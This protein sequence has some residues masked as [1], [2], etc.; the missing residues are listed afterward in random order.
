MLCDEVSIHPTVS[1]MC[2]VV[3]HGFEPHQ[4]L[5]LFSRARHFTRI[6]KYWLVPGT[7]SSVMSQLN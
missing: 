1:I 3:S 2:D 5:P 7:N 4:R 6:A